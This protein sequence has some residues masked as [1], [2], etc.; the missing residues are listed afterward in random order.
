MP[1]VAFN[2]FQQ[3]VEDIAH[4]VHNLSADSFVLF[5][6]NTAPAATN[7]VLADVTQIDYTNLS[8]RALTVSSSLQTSGTYAWT[9]ADITLSASGGAVGPFRYIGVYNDT[10][11]SPADPLVCWYDY[12]TEV[13]LADGESLDVDFDDAGGVLTLV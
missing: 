6:T 3:F 9:L 12:G 1:T 5:L 4:K 7:E 8:S 13:T 10:P 11:T 2:K